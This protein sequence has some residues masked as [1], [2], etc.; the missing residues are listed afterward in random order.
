MSIGQPSVIL[1]LSLMN[2]TMNF[3]LFSTLRHNSS[4]SFVR[5]SPTASAEESFIDDGALGEGVDVSFVDTSCEELTDRV[6]QKQNIVTTTRVQFTCYGPKMYLECTLIVSFGLE[7]VV[8]KSAGS[9][10]SDF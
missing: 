10:S 1:S 5:N 7:T 9:S 6:V 2:V 3:N 4:H 8:S